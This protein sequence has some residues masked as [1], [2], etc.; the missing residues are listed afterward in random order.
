MWTHG[1]CL[2]SANASSYRRSRRTLCIQIEQGRRGHPR[3]SLQGSRESVTRSLQ[4]LEFQSDC[5]P[6]KGCEQ[7]NSLYFH[8]QNE[9][10]AVV[11]S[12]AAVSAKTTGQY[13]SILCQ[14]SND[15]KRDTFAIG[16]EDERG[17]SLEIAGSSVVLS[18]P[19]FATSRCWGD[20]LA[21]ADFRR[22]VAQQHGVTTSS[23]GR[24]QHPRRRQSI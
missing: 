2:L 22:S 6:K 13:R 5:H 8:H 7:Q 21:A 20:G 1:C 11:R 15:E 10:S 24:L 14:D 9:F 17:S 19:P 18:V 16:T 23:A 3:R 4:G 12:R